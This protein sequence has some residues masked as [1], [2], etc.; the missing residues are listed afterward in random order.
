M[1]S[2]IG[3]IDPQSVLMIAAIAIALLLGNLLFRILKANA[4]LILVILLIVLVLQYGM[5]ISPL[6]LWEEIGNLPQ[7]VLQLVKNW[8][9]NAAT[10]MFSG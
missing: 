4:G 2:L 9:L 8:D 1:D 7:D 6:Q 10:F 3:S 5:G